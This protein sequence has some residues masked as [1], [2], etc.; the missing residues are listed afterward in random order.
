L[1]NTSDIVVEH[2]DMKYELIFKKIKT[3]LGED[4][5]IE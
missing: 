1:N 5:G 4:G 3:A 2:F